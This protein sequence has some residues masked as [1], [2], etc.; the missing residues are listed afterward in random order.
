MFAKAYRIASE[1]TFPVVCNTAYRKGQVI[2]DL[3][4][5]IILNDQGWLAS[6]YHNVKDYLRVRNQIESMGKNPTPVAAIDCL[7]GWKNYKLAEEHSFPEA[8]LFIGRFD[9]FPS[10]SVKYFPTL[11]DPDSL[12][13]GTSVCKLGYPLN[14]ISVTYFK[15]IDTFD[16][17]GEVTIFPLEGIYTRNV[18]LKQ[19]N[20]PNICYIETSS[21]CLKGHSGGPLVNVDGHLW[22]VSVFS[23]SFGGKSPKN[24]ILSPG[25]C[26]HPRTFQHYLDNLDI[27]YKKL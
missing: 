22:G 5:F 21:P 16:I 18:T 2:A 19:Q 14:D 9:N 15:D 10:S 4:S 12:K 26:I 13:I 11:V 23:I 17:K 25:Y 1:Y 27:K 24:Q 20:N 8:D 6:A 3:G 7:W